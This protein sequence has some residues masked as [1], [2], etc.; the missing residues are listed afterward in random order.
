MFC[1]LCRVMKALGDAGVPVPKVLALC[2]DP[3]YVT[4]CC[5]RWGTYQLYIGGMN[6]S[7]PSLRHPLLKPQPHNTPTH[8]PLNQHILI[9]VSPFQFGDS[10][11]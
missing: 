6:C 10:L 8:P 2:E 11:H 1:A 4:Q 3:R 5:V 9:A 7:A